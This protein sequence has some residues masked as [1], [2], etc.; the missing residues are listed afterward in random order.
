MSAIIN[1]KRGAFSDGPGGT[2]KT[3]LYYSYTYEGNFTLP[4][5]YTGIVTN[6]SEC[7]KI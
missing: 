4:L 7:S 2:G 1:F 6:I 5:D 3:Y